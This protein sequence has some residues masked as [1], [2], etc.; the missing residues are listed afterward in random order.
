MCLSTIKEMPRVS[1]DQRTYKVYNT[2]KDLKKR[3][4]RRRSGEIGEAPGET[5]DGKQAM[6]Q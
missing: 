4:R 2:I 6:K 5:T 1:H 3:R